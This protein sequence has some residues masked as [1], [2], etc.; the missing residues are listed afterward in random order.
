MSGKYT[1]CE[2]RLPGP[3]I[4]VGRGVCVVHGRRCPVLIET[5]KGRTRTGLS[6][7]TTAEP[8]EVSL[9]LREMG[10]RVYRVQF[11]STAGAWIARAIDWD[12]AA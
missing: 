2:V 8:F 10:W 12:V 3:I 1:E 5:S 9:A 4:V 11:D 7:S 6:A